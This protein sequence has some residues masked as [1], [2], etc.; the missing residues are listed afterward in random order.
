[1]FKKNVNPKI[2]QF[3][4]RVY[5]LFI[6]NNQILMSDETIN[7]FRFT[8][9]PGGGVEKG[10]GILDALKRELFEEGEIEAYDF[11]HFY[12]TDF[13]QVS[14]FNPQ[15]QIISIYY[16][17]KANICWKNKNGEDNTLNRKHEWNLFF[18]PLNE[19]NEDIFTFPIDKLVYKKLKNYLLSLP[20]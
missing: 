19:V 14:A 16:L 4:I 18:Q 2:I 12:T 7:D 6:Q 10:E 20:Q 3:N 8:K 5:G 1:M 17:F 9:F 15:D 13:F 11:E